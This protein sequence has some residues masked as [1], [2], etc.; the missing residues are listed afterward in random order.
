M[1]SEQDMKNQ[2]QSDGGVTVFVYWNE[3]EHC[4][5]A[6]TANSDYMAE[7]VGDAIDGAIADEIRYRV[8]QKER[9]NRKS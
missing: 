4:Y 7:T 3:Q 5:N 1:I 9:A 2:I 8:V 6:T